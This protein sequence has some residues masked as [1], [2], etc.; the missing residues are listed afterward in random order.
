MK[1]SYV[2]NHAMSEQ[3]QTIMRREKL[4][5]PIVISLA[6]EFGCGL[7]GLENR[8]KSYRSAKEKVSVRSSV[9]DFFKMNDMVRYTFI[10]PEE[11]FGNTVNSMIEVMD[12]YGIT[13]R[14]AINCWKENCV[15]YNGI[16][17]L[18]RIKGI[19]VEIQIHT[20]SSYRTYVSKYVPAYKQYRAEN[21]EIQK[22]ILHHR[23]MNISRGQKM[24]M[25][26]DKINTNIIKENVV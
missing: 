25:N 24:P 6:K 12:N 4:I 1:N 5:T 20:E 8:I 18:T 2:E 10:V 16:V 13:V 11:T 17:L 19:N 15:E 3:Y 26:A 14:K 21:D 7:A 22:E 23:L 9:N